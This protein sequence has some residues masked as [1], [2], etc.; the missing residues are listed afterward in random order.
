MITGG[1]FVEGVLTEMAG[2]L[3]S[4][5]A[6]RTMGAGCFSATR[7]GTSGSCL[8]VGRAAAGFAGT[9]STFCWDFGTSTGA[10]GGAVTFTG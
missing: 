2:G 4:G 1:L 10:A 3:T 7:T 8:G 5:A 9:G 6:W